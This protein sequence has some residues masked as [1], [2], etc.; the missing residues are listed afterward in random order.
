VVAISFVI[1][2]LVLATTSQ[3]AFSISHW[4][5]LALFTL[6]ILIGA[7]AARGRAAAFSTGSRVAL[8]SIWGLAAWSLLSMLWASSSADAWIAADRTILYAA[9]FTLPFAFSLPR[10]SLAAA[11]WSLSAGISV[12]A[13]YTLGHLLV[14]GSSLFLAGR[15]NA[16][17][18]YRN[19][20]ALLFAL[21]VWPLVIATAARPYRRGVRA[22]AFALAT[23]CLGLAFLTQ[24]RG[25]V[26]G[27]LA[28]G[29][30]ALCLG[31]DR[32]RRAWVALL[33]VGGV[34]LASP[35]LL[36]PYH[37]FQNGRLAH[38]PHE[39]TVAAL[40]LLV[41]TIVAFLV[42]ML[43]AV[44]DN[45]LRAHSAQMRTLRPA[46]RIALAAVVLVGVVGGLA[47]IGNPITYAQRKWD[48]FRNL[49][50]STNTASTR[51]L[52][53][54]GQRYDLWR[55]AVK[56]FRAHPL[57]GVG[58]DNYAFGYYRYRA[59]NRNLNDPHSL[60]FALLGE[61]G[62]VGIVLFAAFLI[63]IALALR[64]GWRTLPV[65]FRRHAVAPAAAGVVLIGQSLVDW[66]WLIPGLTAVGLL[67]LA[68]STAMADSG[69]AERPRE[70]DASPSR[71]GWA[72]AARYLWLGVLT[73][74]ALS[75]LALFI[76]DAYVQR[77]RSLINNPVAEL[78]AARTAS[79][80]D[81]WS[82]TPHYLEASALETMGRRSLAHRQLLDALS[83]EPGNFAT[84]GVLG[85][86]EAR[87]GNFAAA[88]AYYRRALAL[89]PL[90]AGLRQ[91]A[92]IH[93]VLRRGRPSGTG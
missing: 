91:L 60:L 15:L 89:N 64:R 56:E 9:L 74:A 16:P 67:S 52:S 72:S 76:S 11:G 75:V 30:V 85:D 4:A 81:P 58:A 46:A 31:P 83:L 48:E 14:D 29:A 2:L 51:L 38:I 66:I 10:T 84:L 63:G 70:A 13:L 34:A 45:G 28:G 62:V 22:A 68:L 3:G 80:F 55:V 93:R 18:N 53:V 24:S 87:R 36:R 71:R 8:V 7:W 69:T 42:G 44:F 49:Q 65:G 37:A 86:F 78:S 19:A 50:A 25:I 23:L 77:A 79:T 47:A 92:R 21:P 39:I 17:V 27:L 40:A 6:A 32:V 35:W 41:L 33:A 88:Q 5:P 90:D 59:T 73:V 20:T 1:L 82:V 43:L 26:I 57:Q 54:G 12:V 61:E